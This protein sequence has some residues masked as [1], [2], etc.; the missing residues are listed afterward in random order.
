MRLFGFFRAL[1]IP[2][3]GGILFLAFAFST[4]FTAEVVE[5]LV[6]DDVSR[7]SYDPHG[8]T[9]PKSGRRKSV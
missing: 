5:D 2:F 1:R 6:V 3:G 9:E 7:K 4:S 8:Y